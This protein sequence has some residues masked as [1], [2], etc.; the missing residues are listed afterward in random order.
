MAKSATP[1]RII[2]LIAKRGFVFTRQRGSHAV[3]VRASDKATVVV[4]MH[5][6][7]ISKGTL[8]R[9]LKIAGLT[10]DDL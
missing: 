8:H 3:Y 2:A 10:A 5:A 7:D 1:R 9:I 4:P 6:R